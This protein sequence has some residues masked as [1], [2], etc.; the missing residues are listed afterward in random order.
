MNTVKV[1]LPY[2]NSDMRWMSGLQLEDYP[3]V[4]RPGE[5]REI[6]AELWKRIKGHSPLTDDPAALSAW[7]PRQ[8]RFEMLRS[9]WRQERAAR[10]QKGVADYQRRAIAEEVE[11][12][13]ALEHAK[14]ISALREKAK[15]KLNFTEER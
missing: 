9:Q 4:W 10:R 8:G 7:E 6:P 3:D 5:I 15:K 14:K 1:M 12:E 13:L 11:K 2:P